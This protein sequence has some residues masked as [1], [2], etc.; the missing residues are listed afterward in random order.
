MSDEKPNERPFFRSVGVRILNALYF[1]L[2]LKY[3]HSNN[4]DEFWAEALSTIDRDTA[5]R[6][7][8][9]GARSL[10]WLETEMRDRSWAWKDGP[11]P[12]T[13]RRASPQYERR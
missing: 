13:P 5:R 8:G 11:P 10:E 3:G 4:T 1:H 2:N 12:T 6:I 9:M 7:R